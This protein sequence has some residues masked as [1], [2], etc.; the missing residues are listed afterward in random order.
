MWNELEEDEDDAGSENDEN[1]VQHVADIRYEMNE[2]MN[3]PEDGDGHIDCE[4][5]D[6]GD[7]DVPVGRPY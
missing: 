2:E 4:E 6:T 5:D 3:T 1:S 7:D